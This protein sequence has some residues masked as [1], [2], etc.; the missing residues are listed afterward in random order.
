MIPYSLRLFALPLALALT[1]CATP[2][3]TA[4]FEV[5]EASEAAAALGAR[6]SPV[7][8]AAQAEGDAAPSSEA[9][10]KQLANPVASLISFPFQLN[11]DQDIG[12]RDDGE[13]FLLNV[14]PVIPFSLNEDWNLISRTIL[15]IVSQEDIFPGAGDQTGLGDVVQSLFF[16]P[17]QSPLVWGVGPVFLIPTA[18]EDE[19]GGEKWGIGPT[20]VALRQSGPWTYGG[21]ANHIWSFAGDDD[22]ADVNATF[23]QPF[24]SYTTPSA[25]TYALNTESTYDWEAEKWSVPV[26]LAV[27]K[28]TRFGGQLM[29][30]GAG[31]RY[32]VESPRSGPEGLG[33]RI[34]ITPLFP[35]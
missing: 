22:R 12:P 20:G 33:F 13:R 26:N 21:L 30:I 15:P 3:A 6:S 35:R 16:S 4:R 1:G 24:V 2:S 10:A 31:L 18:T 28:V 34:T 25:Y 17:V 32:W 11:Y 14:Q 19:L 9:L 5:A 8:V 7:P 23:L 27:S 29:S